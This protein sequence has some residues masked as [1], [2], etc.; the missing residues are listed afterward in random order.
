MRKWIHETLS[1]AKLQ[2]SPTNFSVVQESEK[3]QRGDPFD[4]LWVKFEFEEAV[5]DDEVMWDIRYLLM[6]SKLNK[7]AG[8]PRELHNLREKILISR[9]SNSERVRK[10]RSG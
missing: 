4:V 8:F 3:P 7:I 9:D 10:R 1:Q 6:G 2:S 5:W